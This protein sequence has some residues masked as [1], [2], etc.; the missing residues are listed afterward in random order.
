MASS[1]AAS[2]CTQARIRDAGGRAAASLPPLAASRISRHESISS[3]AS[4]QDCA[5]APRL[6]G[7]SSGDRI[8]SRGLASAKDSGSTPGRL[9]GTR[10][11]RVARDFASKPVSPAGAIL[12]CPACRSGRQSP[13]AWS[14]L[15]SRNTRTAAEKITEPGF[16]RPAGGATGMP[17]R[18]PVIDC[19]RYPADPACSP[20]TSTSDD[21]TI[22][23]NSI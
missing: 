19:P 12:G 2:R 4:G 13:R 22:Q 21:Q 1:S 18:G 16:S 17:V 15:A 8:G 6:A 14:D 5:P 23:R 20:T 9:P 10:R 11:A 3:R 7:T